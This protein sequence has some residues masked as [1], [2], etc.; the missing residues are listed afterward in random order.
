MGKLLLHTLL[1]IVVFAAGNAAKAQAPGQ[2]RFQSDP[3]TF[4]PKVIATKNGQLISVL[5]T[6]RGAGPLSTYNT[7]L[8]RTD[9]SMSVVSNT[10]LPNVTVADMLEARNGD[11]VLSGLGW[12]AGGGSSA[13]PFVMRL[14]AAGQL[15]WRYN[16]IRRPAVS[17]F[18]YEHRLAESPS[19]KIYFQWWTATANDHAVVCVSMA[20]NL[21]WTRRLLYPS[22]FTFTDMVCGF[23]GNLLVSGTFNGTESSGLMGID[24]LGTL[25]FTK[26]L[27]GGYV[28]R[29]IIKDDAAQKYWFCGE[30]YNSRNRQ[31]RTSFVGR[32]EADVQNRS[33]VSASLLDQTIFRC[34][35][36]YFSYNIDAAGNLYCVAA[37]RTTA[38]PSRP[39]YTPGGMY[40]QVP[41]YKMDT[42]LNVAWR[43][44]YTVPAYRGPLFLGSALE[45]ALLNGRLV[46]GLET[47]TSTGGAPPV[48]TSWLQIVDTAGDAGRGCFATPEDY[49]VQKQTLRLDAFSTGRFV[50]PATGLLSR[51]TTVETNN[52][53]LPLE[54]NCLRKQKPVSKF[55]TVRL[56]N[57]SGPPGVVCEGAAHDFFDS[58]YYEPQTWRW[59]FP[60]EA[61]LSAADSS[62][63]PH[64]RNVRFTQPGTYTVK[65]IVENQQGVDSSE[66]TITVIAAALKPDL[67]EDTTLCPGG[68]AMLVY[69]DG[70]YETHF[71]QQV[72]GP[73]YSTADTVYVGPGQYT[74]TVTSPCGRAT[75]TKNIAA[76]QS[77]TAGFNVSGA[78]GSTAVSFL[79]TSSLNGSASATFQWQFMNI[80]GNVLGTSALAAPTFNYPSFDSVRAKLIV[81]DSQG[82]VVPDTTE[83][84]FLLS[85][86]P[87][88]SFT[89]A[90]SCGRLDASFTATASVAGG[91][92]QQ[93][94]W[95]FGDGRQSAV[96]N[97]VH[98]YAS[99]GTY[100]VQFAAVSATGC[101]SDVFRQQVTIRA[102]PVADFAYGNDACEG[103]PFVLRD[104]SRVQASTLTGYAWSIPALNQL[105][106]TAA[107]QP[108]VPTAGTVTVY[109][110]VTS[111]QGCTSDTA[112]QTILVEST[113]VAD[114]ATA[115]GCGGQTMA[116]ASG[117]AVATGA[118][119]RYSWA[120]SNGLSASSAA[121]SFNFPVGDYAVTHS[122]ATANG[123]ASVPV[124]KA[125]KIFPLPQP[126]FVHGLPC[127]DA[128]VAFTNTTVNPSSTAWTWSVNGAAFST[129]TNTVYRFASPGRYNVSLGAT[130]AN[131]CTASV[132]KTVSVEDAQLKLTA[133]RNP[134]VESDVIILQTGMAM[135]YSVVSWKPYALFPA[136]TQKSQRLTVDSSLTIEVTSRSQSGCPDTA[137]LELVVSP[138]D[139]VYVPNAFTPNN[140]GQ[141]DVLRVR[142]KMASMELI[143]YNRWGGAVF[144]TTDIGKGWDGTLRGLAL[145]TGTYVYIL[146]GKRANGQ[147]VQRKG[148]VTL[149]R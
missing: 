121:G 26:R 76:A 130:D 24:S 123:C 39:V 85:P 79:N 51:V 144:R 13:T 21:L 126:S 65:L 86:R 15:V 6:Q 147:A 54:Y 69:N 10:G 109:H 119:A 47:L 115:N 84:R 136:Q 113:P 31:Y 1:L 61:D 66:R 96:Q 32:A 41:V 98:T 80:A 56:G 33:S 40:L 62:C 133:S 110:T 9:A 78:C 29:K 2:Y 141:N 37:D 132:N 4:F 49:S 128:D 102:K 125:V 73:F 67:G 103:K 90:E 38:V 71:F 116:F 108:V 42:A 77:P 18:S 3:A 58:S 88:A 45:P 137:W 124:T 55:G 143:I 35:Q 104:A 34:R 23:D 43:K 82:C 89:V 59:V 134:A 68:T 91:A 72:G 60:R 11:L 83:K 19:E 112:Q 7:I 87:T 117:A 44:R 100:D 101:T 63:F 114:F 28:I 52:A 138:L 30:H 46:M 95:A 5:V 149:I 20:G 48:T 94:I 36:P 131:G 145:D 148:T 16:G 50:V 53:S 92:L 118:I 75:A 122:V 17:Q 27:D 93:Y 105:Y 106:G 120:T 64:I 129:A 135:P 74:L 25:A 22:N 139:D 57:G 146:T 111:A 12:P 8:Q 140:D 127:F 142:G 99:A 81:T 97:P 14:T 70:P 107:I